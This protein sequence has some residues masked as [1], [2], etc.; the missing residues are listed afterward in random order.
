M[1]EEGKVVEQG[2]SGTS[3]SP[4]ARVK[5]G[6]SSESADCSV[7]VD[8]ADL[9]LEDDV[10]EMVTRNVFTWLRGEDGFPVAERA[11]RE[12]EWIDNLQSDD[13]G[14]IEGDTLSSFGGGNSGRW[15]LGV[16][17][18]RSNSF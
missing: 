5:N 7:A 8:Y 18:Q 12:H 9:D 10:S 17:T 3:S 13:D 15:L 14:P 6:L 4:S 16:S 2:R 11:I 1:C